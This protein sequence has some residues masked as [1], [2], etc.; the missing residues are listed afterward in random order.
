MLRKILLTAV[1]LFV[2]TKFGDVRL[3]RLWL[4]AA[5]SIGFLVLLALVRPFKRAEDLY[6]ACCS[7]LLLTLC[8]L[9]G[10]AIKLCEDE[11]WVHSC[12][13]F[14]GL[15]GSYQANVFVVVITVVMLAVSLGVIAVK[16]YMTV[17][18]GT[19]RLAV[20]GREPVLEL[21]VDCSFHCFLSHAWRTGQDQTHTVARQLQLLVPE[22]K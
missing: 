15:G 4:A 1:V 19:I 17:R 6:L 16:T 12:E 2:D 20:T 22:I 21:P 10:I 5:V 14:L 3:L 7:N 18:T 8:F 11:A 9:S 13:E